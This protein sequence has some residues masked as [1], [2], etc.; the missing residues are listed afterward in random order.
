M[1]VQKTVSAFN[2][3]SAAV[4]YTASTF[5]ANGTGWLSVSPASG[6]VSP[7]ANVLQIAADLSGLAS[8]VQTGTVRLVFGDG[9]T[10]AIQVLASWR[11]E[12]PPIFRG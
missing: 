8:G 6:A 10:G 5:T 11:R 2:P 12:T 4:T 9:S 3:S 7:G 1:P